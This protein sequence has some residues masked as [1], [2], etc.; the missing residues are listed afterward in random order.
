MKIRWVQFAVVALAFTACTWAQDASGDRSCTD[1][2]GKVRLP[3]PQE[4]QQDPAAKPVGQET[5]ERGQPESQPPTLPAGA[6]AGH[7]PSSTNSVDDGTPAPPAT[8]VTQNGQPYRSLERSFARNFVADQKNF[9]TSPL[10]LRLDDAE[11]IVP[12]VGA[13]TVVTLSDGSIE[14]KLPTS[15]TL[16]K[17]SKSFSD[18]GAAAYGGGVASAY[19]LSLATHNDHMRETAVLSGEAALNAL[20]ITEGIKYIAGR[21]RPLENDGTGRFLNGGSSF[22]SGHSSGAWAIASVIAREY[23]GPLTQLLAYGGAAAISAARVTGRQHFTSDVLVGGA[24]GWF[25][26]RQVYNAHHAREYSDAAYGTFERDRGSGNPENI[27]SPYVPLDSWIYPVIDRLAAM[28]YIQTGFAGMRPWTRMECTRILEEVSAKLVG[29]TGT[30]ASA[31]ELYEVLKAE[32]ALESRRRAGDRNLGVEVESVYTRFTGISGMPLTDGYHF[33]QTLVNDYGRPYQEGFNLVTGF[34]SHA[35]AGPLTFYVRGEYQHAPSA[36]PLSLSAR[37]AAATADNLPSIAPATL[38][39]AVNR[40]RLLDAYVALNL[41]NWQFSFGKQSL[42]WGPGIGGAMM[43]S[44]NAEPITMVRMNRV[45]PFK[46]P[47]ILG[48]LGPIRTEGFFGQLS[49]HEFLVSPN[50][51]TGSYGQ[52]L[53]PQPYIHGQRISFK[54]TPDLELGFSRTTVYGGPGYPLTWHTFFRSLVSTGN[55]LAGNA[56][57]PGDRRSGMDFTYR[58]PGLRKWLTF[59][60]DGFTEDQYSPIAYP[61]RSIWRAGLY[62]SR[63]PSLPKLDMRLEGSYSDNPLGGAVGPGYYYFNATWRNGYT[64]DGNLLG[65][66]IGRA[67]QGAQAWATYHVDARSFVQMSFRH[68]KVSRE[69][70]AGGGTLTDVAVRADL[71]VHS[72][73]SISSSV[74]YERWIFPMVAPN[75]Q[76]NVTT[77][78]QFS[79]WP[80]NWG[81]H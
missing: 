80:R 50:G 2:S 29:E 61:D 65:N 77:S 4:K 30:N 81:R 28:G 55:T 44:N 68:Q 3:C 54:P 19:L 67:G 73:M 22:P 6:S 70:I 26:G 33:G 71:W 43:F 79:Y 47:S 1:L 69:F 35:E 75:S 45:T 12:L 76:T 24:I 11:W 49:G 17:R 57:K 8:R 18:Y 37:Q 40:F 16:I 27:G 51:L 20:L 23:P 21:N 58:L 7:V 42:S 10:K 5:I 14:Q 56:N 59:Y 60:G 15:A 64:N 46:L 9:W 39:P 66:W 31:K 13:M 62:L 74:T 36:P 48:W 72:A 78:V 63:F 25:V 38:M 52:S 34:S 32:F 53:D 41:N